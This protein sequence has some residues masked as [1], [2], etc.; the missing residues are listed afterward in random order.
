MQEAGELSERQERKSS[1]AVTASVGAFGTKQENAQRISVP[2][3]N[4]RESHGRINRHSIQCAAADLDFQNQIRRRIDVQINIV[5][6][7]DGRFVLDPEALIG[8]ESPLKAFPTKGHG[9][10]TGHVNFHFLGKSLQQPGQQILVA[11]VP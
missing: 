10:E 9:S 4:L 1:A 11:F 5:T 2:A 7:A 8:F 6:P 3:P